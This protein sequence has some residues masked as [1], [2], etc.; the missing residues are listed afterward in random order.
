M[1]KINTL[2]KEYRILLD[3]LKQYG[4]YTNKP[5]ITT[6]NHIL[7]AL[8]EYSNSENLDAIRKMNDSLYLPRGGLSEFYIWH[9]DYDERILLN[10]SL[11]KVK[12]TI[13]NIL[14]DDVNEY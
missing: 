6:V 7:F 8:E 12:D 1:D 13:W 9:N 5:Q 3:N 11:D 14:H 2:K 4:D 10:E